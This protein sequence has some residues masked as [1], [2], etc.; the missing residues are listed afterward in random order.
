MGWKY[1]IV[2]LDQFRPG[3]VSCGFSQSY[4]Q[5]GWQPE[6]QGPTLRSDTRAVTTQTFIL[7]IP[8]L[9]YTYLGFIGFGS[10][11]MQCL[12]LLSL[13]PVSFVPN[14]CS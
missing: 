13:L 3:H 8:L 9:V 10:N 11:T 2:D 12:T 4:L 1:I 5:P 7:K 6:G 14:Q